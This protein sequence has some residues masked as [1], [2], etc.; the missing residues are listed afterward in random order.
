M[1]P[2][3]PNFGVLAQLLPQPLLGPV[4]PGRCSSS[5][6]YFLK[7]LLDEGTPE[8]ADVPTGSPSLAPRRGEP[9]MDGGRVTTGVSFS[10]S[11]QR[12][13]EEIKMP[14]CCHR[15]W[16]P[17]GVFCSGSMSSQTEAWGSGRERLPRHWEAGRTGSGPTKGQH[18]PFPHP[19]R[20]REEQRPSYPAAPAVGAASPPAG[21]R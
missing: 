12:K 8:R 17:C 21:P 11:N 14:R 9:V 1:D 18:S 5:T 4:R 19:T 7:G 15:F 20:A 2:F 13:G 6:T 3:A 10:S 16:G